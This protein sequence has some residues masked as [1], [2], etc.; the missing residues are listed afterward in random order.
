M[1]VVRLSALSTGR[2]YPQEIFLVLISVRGWVNPR[3]IVQPRLSQPQGHSAAGRI[4]SMKK[5]NDTIGNWT[6][7]LLAC[8]AVPQQTA[9]PRAPTQA[10]YHHTLLPKNMVNLEILFPI[11]RI[12]EISMVKISASLQGHTCIQICFSSPFIHRVYLE[13]FH[14][15]QQLSRGL[16]PTRNL[17]SIFTM[18]VGSIEDT[19]TILIFNN[20]LS[21]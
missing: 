13:S 14:S 20:A 15:A 5:S 19:L 12:Q 8:R 3:A 7:D 2:L 21:H 10:I 1:K 9:P 16:S 4:M 17:K 6:R 18:L 11:T